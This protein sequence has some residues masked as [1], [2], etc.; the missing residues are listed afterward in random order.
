MK[1]E[2]VIWSMV[3]SARLHRRGARKFLR[4][5]MPF[6]ALE[7]QSRA[8]EA[9]NWARM[10]KGESVASLRVAT[11]ERVKLMAVAV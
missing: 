6:D 7:F 11:L 8:A 5:D 4:I 10:L 2:T 3:R 9:M 1:P